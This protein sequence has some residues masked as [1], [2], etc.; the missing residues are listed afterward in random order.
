MADI[1]K[2]IVADSSADLLTLEGFPFASAPLKILTSEHYY[3]DDEKLD[4]DTFTDDMLHYDGKSSTACPS[5]EDWLRAFDDAEELFC[6]TISSNLSGSYN[7]ACVAKQTYEEE[8]PGRRVFVYDSLSTGPEMHLV[9]LKIRERIEAGDDFDTICAAVT[10]YAKQTHLLFML[11]SMRNLANN[12][13]VSHIAA[14][15]A[16]ILGIRAVGIASDVGTLQMLGKHRGEKKGLTA[17]VDHMAEYGHQ[18]GRVLITHVGNE[19]AALRVKDMLLKKNPNLDI[20]IRRCRGLC[21]FYA[22][23]GGLLIGFEAF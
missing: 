11:E 12:G 22:E 17:M 13:R 21:S 10:A 20:G 7:A 5:P 15:A 19:P 6:L 3:V 1:R 2:K 14:K 18:T 23:K 4:V 16:G 8:H 9:A